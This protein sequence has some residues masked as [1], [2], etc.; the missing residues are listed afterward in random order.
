MKLQ[1]RLK[2]VRTA[3]NLTLKEFAARSG[4]SV[5][6]L[7][8][9]ERGRTTPSLGTLKLLATALGMTVI[10]VL[11][12]VDFAGEAT[13]TSLPA[14]LPDLLADTEYGHELTPEWL[15]MLSKIHLRGRRP[16]TK[17]DWLELYLYL[18]R[19]LEAEG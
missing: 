17:R 16:Q 8:D 1:E 9:L 19:L 2:E 11:T 5:S 10:D 15:A 7:S 18:K 4:V 12:G 6:Y 13:D 3:H 14:G